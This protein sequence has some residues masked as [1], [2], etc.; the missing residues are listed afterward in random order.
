VEAS[1]FVSFDLF[2]DTLIIDNDTI[3]IEHEEVILPNDSIPA[4][5]LGRKSAKKTFSFGSPSWWLEYIS[6][7][8]SACFG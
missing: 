3:Y 6:A 4:A 2:S 7:F 8:L 5:D 1:E